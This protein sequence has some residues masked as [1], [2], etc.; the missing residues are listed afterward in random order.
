MGR[1]ANVSFR[2]DITDLRKELKKIPGVTDVEAKR[3]V[4]KLT[5]S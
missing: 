3:M 5:A 1:E 2:A 4:T